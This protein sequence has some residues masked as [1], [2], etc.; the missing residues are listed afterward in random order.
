M[1]DT[2]T[3]CPNCGFEVADEAECSLCGHEIDDE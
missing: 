3:R 2:R 1:D